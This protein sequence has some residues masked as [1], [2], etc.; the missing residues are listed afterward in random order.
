M[1]VE[2]WVCA[3]RRLLAPPR[4][5]HLCVQ[6]ESAA[7]VAVAFIA[8]PAWPVSQ[9]PSHT[10]VSRAAGALPAG[11]FVRRVLLLC[12]PQPCPPRWAALCVAPLRP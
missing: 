4:S 6:R 7:A 11:T 8:E 1:V 2:N 3:H 12:H 5:W 9:Q 10:C